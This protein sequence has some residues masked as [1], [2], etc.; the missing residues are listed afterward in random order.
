[1]RK[2]K[3][4]FLNHPRLP[5]EGQFPILKGMA[6]VSGEMQMEG[7]VELEEKMKPDVKSRQRKGG[8][9]YLPLDCYKQAR[10]ALEMMKTNQEGKTGYEEVLEEMG[11]KEKEV[12]AQVEAMEQDIETK[13]KESGRKIQEEN[14]LERRRSKLF[15]SNEDVNEGEESFDKGKWDQ[16][17]EKGTLRPMGAQLPILIKGA[18]GQYVPWAS[19]DLEGLVTHIPDI[20]EGTGKWIRVFEEETMGKL[21]AV[22][23]IKA[24]LA[25]TVGGAKMG[26][27]LQTASLDRAV[28]SHNMDGIIFDAFRPAVWQA[29]RAEYPIRL[30]P[31]SLKGDELKETE[32][33]TTYVQRQLK[34]WKQETEG[35]PETDPLMAT[36]FRQAVIDAMPPAVKCRLEDV[37]GLTSKT[38]KEFCDHVSHAVEQFRKNEQKLKNQ[39]K[40]LQRKLT[41][42][43]LE[44]LT[45]KNKKKIQASVKKEE[46]EQMSVMSPV[47]APPPTIQPNPPTAIP[48]TAHLTP[49]PIINVYTQQPGP[50]GWRKR[51]AQ[52]GQRGRGR[53][54]TGPPGLCWGCGQPGHSKI[55]CPNNPW[56]QHPQG[57]RG[58]NW[59]QPNRGTVQGPVNP[60]GGPNQGF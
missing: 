8:E 15:D 47:S 13:M 25:K 59:P 58:E 21:L 14:K 6:E 50:M 11:R 2:R 40:E 39:E 35:N 53:P 37:V 42:L 29:L 45:K 16:G 30:D 5:P 43:Q 9:E 44:E 36:L 3:S 46:A 51:P 33:P 22:G 26:E 52:R 12:E 38:H 32:N 54:T 57:A 18:Q 17:R 49:V 1:Q 19:Q 60:W 28:N 41:Q 56:Q 7:Q 23:D 55:D 10:I 31:K 4:C 20:H 24:L 48:L 34:R 27:I